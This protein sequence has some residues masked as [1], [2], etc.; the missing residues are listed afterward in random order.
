MRVYHLGVPIFNWDEL[1]LMRCTECGCNPEIRFYE[2]LAL[3]PG[4]MMLRCP[5]CRKAREVAVDGYVRPDDPM[6][7][8]AWAAVGGG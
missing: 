2:S 8:E 4:H 7:Y 6:D 3:D 1:R 5:K